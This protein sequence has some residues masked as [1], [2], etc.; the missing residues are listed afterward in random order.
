[1]QREPKYV[2]INVST[3]LF[4][5]ASYMMTSYTRYLKKIDKRFKKNIQ[6][7]VSYVNSCRSCSHNHTKELIN[8]GTSNQVLIT[9]FDSHTFKHLKLEHALALIFAQHYAF[10]NGNYD[11]EAFERVIDFYGKDIAFGIMSTIKICCFRSAHYI[12]LENLGDRLHFRKLSEARF[13]TDLYNSFFIFSLTP[14]VF[15]FNLFR[16]QVDFLDGK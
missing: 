2:P 8:S 16:K 5:E 6:Q 13:F 11:Q 4:F 7:S 1:M 12:A 9:M 10:T 15:L 3:T 14:F